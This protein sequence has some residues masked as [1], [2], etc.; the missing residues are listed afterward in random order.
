MAIPKIPEELTRNYWQTNK[1]TIAKMAGF[2]GMSQAM[3]EVQ[4]AYDGIR[5]SRLDP[6]EANRG[7]AYLSMV[8]FEMRS[9]KANLELAKVVG[10]R[11]KVDQVCKCARETETRY[12]ANPLIPASARQLA[13]RIAAA[14]AG[15]WTELGRLHHAWMDTRHELVKRLQGEYKVLG[16]ALGSIRNEATFFAILPDP[17][18]E[19]L[20]SAVMEQSRLMATNIGAHSDLPA[21][22]ADDWE[23]VG[24]DKW[25]NVPDGAPV[26]Q[27]AHELQALVDR[28]LREVA[29]ANPSSFRD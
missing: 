11:Q 12:L 8:Q 2:T 21:R 18:A 4:T 25:Y 24:Q 1:G 6:S 23:W 14:A 19:K 28:S 7:E 26:R 27:K 3:D 17:A 16:I 22:L 13:S 9:V 29:L 15:F 10:L 5:W 20:K